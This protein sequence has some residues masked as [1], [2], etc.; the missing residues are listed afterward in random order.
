MGVSMRSHRV[1]A[2]PRIWSAIVVGILVTNL[3]LV[4]SGAPSAESA[5]SPKEVYGYSCC[6]GGFGS[7]AYRPGQAISIDWI[8]TASGAKR[9][10]SKTVELSASATGPFPSVSVLKQ[11]LTKSPP[12][13]GPLSFSA[14]PI[15]VS[16]QS[17]ASPVSILHVPAA[18]KPGYYALTIT[19]VKGNFTSHS[20]GIF[21]IRP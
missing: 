2:V 12:G 9:L 7:S 14:S 15:H 21:T 3:G 6:G 16:D 10:R 5:S 19:V 18:A 20:I 1:L 13:S 11:T 4:G 8:R 17:T